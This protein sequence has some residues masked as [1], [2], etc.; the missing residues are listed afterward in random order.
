VADQAD[1]LA[2]LDVQRDAAVD[3]AVAVAEAD[4]AQLDIAGHLVHLDRVDR[5]RHARDVVEDVEDALGGRGRLLRDRDDAAHRIEAHVEAAA[6]GD[7]GGQ[8]ADR[9]L[10]ARDLPDAE[11]PDHQQ[12]EF[13]QEGHGRREQ[14]PD[15]VQFVVDGQVVLVRFAE[16]HRFAL[17][18]GKGLHHADAGNGIGQHVGDLAPDA[19]DLLEAGAQLVA[20]DVDH[21][22]DEGQRHQGDQGQLG[23]NR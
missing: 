15:L 21:P 6:V 16:A 3:G 13:G 14:R 2:G 11:A 7:E 12:A 10:A 5:V 20:H 1:H 23:V 22:G 9:D 17:F 19:V 18:L 4:F 8:R